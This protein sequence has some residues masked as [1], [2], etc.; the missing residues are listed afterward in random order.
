MQQCTNHTVE[1][2]DQI[3][4]DISIICWIGTYLTIQSTIRHVAP[5]SQIALPVTQLQWPWLPGPQFSCPVNGCVCVCVHACMHVCMHACVRACMRSNRSLCSIYVLAKQIFIKHGL[6]TTEVI[7]AWKKVLCI[8]VQIKLL[9][10]WCMT[11]DN[12]SHLCTSV[13]IFCHSAIKLH[14]TNSDIWQSMYDWSWETSIN[15]VWHGFPEESG[16]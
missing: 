6:Q 1:T 13:V 10:Y 9:I 3:H 15:W 12:Y 7:E 4:W 5:H 11:C 2:A 16:G 14:I 8:Y